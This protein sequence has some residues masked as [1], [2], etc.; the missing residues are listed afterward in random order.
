MFQIT[1]TVRILHGY[2]EN[3]GKHQ[4]KKLLLL[5]L[6]YEVGMKAAEKRKGRMKDRESKLE[7]EH[8]FDYEEETSEEKENMEETEKEEKK[9]EEKKKWKVNEG[10]K[11]DPKL[12]T[13]P[14]P[15]LMDPSSQ[16]FYENSFI[17]YFF[18]F[19]PVAYVKNVMLPAT[20]KYAEDNGWDHTP[21]T[22]E[23]FIHIL[24]FMYLMEVVRLPERRLY[25]SGFLQVKRRSLSLPGLPGINIVVVLDSGSALLKLSSIFPIPLP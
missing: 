19:F 1:N 2:L 17:V 21:Y 15:H 11:F 24:G 12:L 6:P 20:N 18:T 14:G 16:I 9:A 22:F 10:W 4:S 23:E 5:S 3:Y 8:E 7:K 25:W 13:H